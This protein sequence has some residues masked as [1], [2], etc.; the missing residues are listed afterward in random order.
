MEAASEGG[1]LRVKAFA[2]TGKTT[3]LRSVAE[4]MSGRKALYLA[5]NR[6]IADEARQKFPRNVRA[7]TAHSVAFR[8]T[9]SLFGDRVEQGFMVVVGGVQEHAN[10]SELRQLC[11]GDDRRA[12]IVVVQT[13][14]R[15]AQSARGQPSVRDVPIEF[16]GRFSESYRSEAASVVSRGAY[17]TW[18]QMV[19]PDSEMP[20]L[21][22]YYLKYWAL[23]RP[24]LPFDAVLFDEAQDANPVL[25][26]LVRDQECQQVFVGDSHQQI[27]RFRGA[28]DAMKQ[29]PGA[30]LPLTKSWRFGP[31]IA[32]WA[33]GLLKMLGEDL[34]LVGG[35]EDG[36]VIEEVKKGSR[37]DAVLCRTNAGAIREVVDGLDAGRAVAVVGGT[38]E[39]V[40]LLG[41]AYDLRR[42]EK[43][44][45]RD[46]SMFAS[47]EELEEFSQTDDGSSYGPIVRTVDE[48][49]RGV[50]RLC[51]RLEQDT[52]DEDEADLVVTTAH[53][54]KG[55]EWP[56]VRFCDDFSSLV[57]EDEDGKAR[58]D[59]DEA[60]LVYVSITRATSMLELNGY[61]ATLKND[62]ERLGGSRHGPDR[63]PSNSYVSGGVAGGG[64]GARG[65]RAKL[66]SV[67]R[68]GTDSTKDERAS[69]VGG[70]V[71]R[72]SEVEFAVTD[73][74]GG[75]STVRLQC[76]CSEAD[77]G[78]S[79]EHVRAFVGA[80]GGLES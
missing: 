26:K 40:A 64:E 38:R 69:G 27:Y 4:A 37:P 60:N 24:R 7:S 71:R 61:G 15:W 41:A 33:N 32:G 8:Q 74:S 43:P 17:Q 55:R 63:E 68:P 18:Q 73:R 78:E 25:L 50:P 14:N 30:E 2:G 11:E 29:A 16:L 54:A 13:L 49:G 56:A 31:Q 70:V 58:L 39:V 59:H 65:W 51:K 77:N 12:A 48:Y 5:F 80:M 1:H 22:D 67:I 57:L 20:V 19:A 6:A 47:W 10:L 34:E 72:I 62:A 75:Q 21:H 53:K 9:K 79:C 35:G 46:L 44:D 42:G 3:T 66:A 76:S 23:R 45:H 28:V 52:K 36:E